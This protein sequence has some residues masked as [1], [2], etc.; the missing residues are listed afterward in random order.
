MRRRSFALCLVSL[1]L[2]P[3]LASAKQRVAPRKWRYI[4]VHHSGTQGGSVRAFEAYHRGIRGMPRGM[5]YHFVIGN[6][7]GLADGAIEEGPRWAKQ[8]PGAHVASALRDPQ[9]GAVLDEIAIGVCLIGNLDTTP[10][11]PKQKQALSG[12][13]ARLQREFAIPR[14]HVLGHSEVRGAHTA[15]PG[16]NLAVADFAHGATAQ[17]VR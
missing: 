8:Q 12:L 6:G 11:S 15:C 2:L 14:E 1:A 13:L 10:P 5:A 16:R 3:T 4:V 17:G 9:T 7:H